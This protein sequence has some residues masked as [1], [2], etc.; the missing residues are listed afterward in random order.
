MFGGVLPGCNATRAALL[1]SKGYVALSLEYFWAEE[2][3][4]LIAVDSLELEY[5]EVIFETRN[6]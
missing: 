3:S 1:A 5:F 6:S 2:E 4:Q